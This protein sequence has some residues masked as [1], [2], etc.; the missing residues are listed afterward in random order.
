MAKKA[1]P[2]RTNTNTGLLQ[3]ALA[4]PDRR[5]LTELVGAIRANTNAL[6]A[7]QKSLAPAS[8]EDAA[9]ES[10]EPHVDE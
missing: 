6:L 8:R 1:V 7:L 3:G 10:K 9:V 5:L 2:P 4:L